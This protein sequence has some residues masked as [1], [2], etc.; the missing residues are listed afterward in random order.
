MIYHL[1]DRTINYWPY[2]S[3]ML[4]YATDP[5]DKYDREFSAGALMVI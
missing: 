2:Y 3:D 5:R 1:E 4:D